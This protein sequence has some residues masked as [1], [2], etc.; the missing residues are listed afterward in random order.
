MLL[1]SYS[2]IINIINIANKAGKTGLTCVDDAPLYANI[3]NILQ[4]KFRCTTRGGLTANCS[5][6]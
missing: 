1:T 6:V 2:N 4:R 5:R 3:I